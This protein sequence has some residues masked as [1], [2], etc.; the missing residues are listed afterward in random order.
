MFSDSATGSMRDSPVVYF[1][2]S[3]Y[4]IIELSLKVGLTCTLH[5]TAL[6]EVYR[7]GIS[8]AIVLLKSGTE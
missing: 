1:D 7:H 3:N 6:T 5:N 2:C 4:H 8:N